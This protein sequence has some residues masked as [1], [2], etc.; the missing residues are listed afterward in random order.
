MLQTWNPW[1]ELE[2]MQRR[3]GRAVRND[4]PGNGVSWVPATDIV[5]DSEGLYLYLDLPDVD[6]GSLE[7]ETEQNSLSVKATRRYR[8]GENQTVHY[9]GR[10]KGTFT[11]TFNVPTSFDL[12]KVTASYDSGVLTLLVPRSE[13]TR[14]RKVDVSTGRTHQGTVE[15]QAQT[16]EAPQVEH[17]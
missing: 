17:A 9:Q 7:V 3:L 14:P 15:V 12:G 11:R 1:Q 10:P 13:S 6:E 4:D 5:E 16:E 2:D 8:K